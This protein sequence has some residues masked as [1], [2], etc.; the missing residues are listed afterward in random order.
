MAISG[1]REARYVIGLMCGTSA[2]GVSAALIKTSGYLRERTVEVVRHLIEPYPQELS[3]RLFR[4]FPPNR[5][6]AEEYAI[7]HRDFG[8]L[9]AEVSIT[10]AEQAGLS[11]R[12]VSEVVVQAPTLIHKRPE[13]N[14]LGVHIEV[15]EAAVIAEMTKVPVVCDLRPSDIAAG[16]HGAPL[17]VYVDYMLFADKKLGRAIQNIGGIA[18]VTFVPADCGLEDL[19]SFDT[20]PGNLVIDGVVKALT[21]GAEEFDRDG[22]RAS[23]GKVS[24][25]L[26][27][28]L[29]GIPYL[30]LTPP[31]TTGREE[32][33]DPFV[34]WF[35]EQARELRLTEDDMVATATAFTAKCIGCHYRE[36]LIPKSHLDE[37]ILY[38]GGAHNK[39]LVRMVTQEV[40][41]ARVRMHDEFGISGDAREAVTWAIL[42]DEAL[43]GYATNVPAASGAT[44]RV[45]L[46][47]IVCTEPGSGKW[48]AS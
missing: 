5:F 27:N 25:A 37:V 46:G 1:K 14:K 44:R 33:G 26:M 30:Q 34:R 13:G 10:V 7:A 47:K 12:N 38:G 32:F 4:L 45:L 48:I 19:L 9:L 23:R 29:M 16:G 31:K 11:I 24:E 18:N 8:R 43:A 42:G 36:F 39:T 21:N 28:R 20:G 17:S 35:M 41:P 15:G 40:A 2:D 3:D 22:E 6:S